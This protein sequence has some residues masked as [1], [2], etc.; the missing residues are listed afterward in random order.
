MLTQVKRILPAIAYPVSTVVLIKLAGYFQHRVLLGR[1]HP[2]EM[3]GLENSLLIIILGFLLL[4]S[5]RFQPWV[6]GMVLT[7][8][9]SVILLD[10]M[11][12]RF[13][14]DLPS[15]HLLPLWFQTGKASQSA[16]SVVNIGD[17]LIFFPLV[18]LL[19][20]GFFF[21]IPK[22]DHPRQ[23]L[24]GVGVLILGLLGFTTVYTTMHK[25]RR[26]QLQHRFQNVAIANLFGPVF[27]HYS[28]AYEWL[29]I[30][31]GGEGGGDF[32]RSIIEDV[33]ATSRAHSTEETPF[34]GLYEGR[35]FIF[36]QLESLQY[37]AIDAEHDG[38]LVMPFLNAARDR[39]NS[40]RL[41]DQ[42]HLGRSADAQFIFL[43]SLHPPATRP[44][45]FTY[46]ANHFYG[47]PRVFAERGYNTF[48]LHPSDRTFWNASVMAQTYG[49]EYRYFNDTLFALSPSENRGWGL[50]D[51]ALYR[52]AQEKAKMSDEPYFMYLVTVMCHHPYSEQANPD[53]D[54]P[55]PNAASM[56][57]SYLRCAGARDAAL[58]DMM[59]ELATTQRGRETVICLVGD[60]EAGLDKR[61]MEAQGYP[62]FP[63]SETVPMMLGSVE[64]FLGMSSEPLLTA[65]RNFGG[66]MDIAPT[67]GHVFSLNMEESVFVGW[68]LFST[69]N[70]GPHYSRVGTW[71]DQA[72]RI[73]V[74]ENP[75]ELQ[76]DRLF[77]ASEMLLQ[78][79]GVDSFRNRSSSKM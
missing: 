34:K 28:D 33:V 53:V 46:P 22:V 58:K 15:L 5:R 7:A 20:I 29:R 17:L 57:A 74:L 52:H 59:K 66:Q 47:L 73:Q 64:E 56:V 65:P 38:R 43:N 62:T 39:V 8:H 67:V 37:F 63:E 11:Y 77:R 10:T 68:N 40:F 18:V 26:A 61:E 55:P 71:M 41:F 1:E 2:I 79:D 27:Y 16:G 50:I 69:Q 76:D 42:T 6:C 13:F 78:S 23:K 75:E 14:K 19:S 32:D 51:S 31:S 54:F 21:R 60:H 35:D 3:H 44:V 49:F 36:I 25:V 24:V 48:Y 4:F 12:F 45:V 72:G 30:K 70:R 9:L